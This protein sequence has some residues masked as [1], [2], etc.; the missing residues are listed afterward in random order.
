MRTFCFD[1]LKLSF[2]TFVYT[3]DASTKDNETQSGDWF[4]E[5]SIHYLQEKYTDT[6]SVC[7]WAGFSFGQEFAYRT[8]ASNNIIKSKASGCQVSCHDILQ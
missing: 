5:T 8:T 3:K 7:T 6:F 1:A 2:T 4:S